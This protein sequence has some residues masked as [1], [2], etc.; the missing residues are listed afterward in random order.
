MKICQRQEK[1]FCEK[2]SQFKLCENDE[3][4]FYSH[5]VP[6]C[7]C[8]DDNNNDYNYNT[9]VDETNVD[10]LCDMNIQ[11]DGSASIGNRLRSSATGNNIVI[12]FTCFFVFMAIALC[13]LIIALKY[14]KR[15][16]T[17]RLAQVQQQAISSG[18]TCLV[19]EPPPAY[20]VAVQLY[21][22]D[23]SVANCSGCQ[24]LNGQ[25]FISAAP[26]GCDLSPVQ[27]LPP[28]YEQAIL[29]QQLKEDR[30]VSSPAP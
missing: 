13:L 5:P 20:S 15:N 22:Q 26:A 19:I 30:T 16:Q 9:Y 3:A 2:N 25:I 8:S 24:Q 18:P 21:P 1:L 28:S 29:V 14:R 27:E 6:K 17:R 10:P 23:L 11:S 7:F 12:S 4:K